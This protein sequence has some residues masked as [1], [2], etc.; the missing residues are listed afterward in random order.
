MAKSTDEYLIFKAEEVVASRGPEY[1]QIIPKISPRYFFSNPRFRSLG[2]VS[3]PNLIDYMDIYEEGDRWTLT[4]IEVAI[5]DATQYLFLPLTQGIPSDSGDHEYGKPAF[6]IE[7]SSSAYGI[8]QWQVF[9]AFAD[10]LFYQKLYNLFLPSENVPEN[11]VNAYINVR[12][13]GVGTF[14]FHTK[15]ELKEPIYSKGAKMEFAEP[16]LLLKFAEHNLRIYQLLSP[17]IDSKS[18]EESPE[19]AGW[20]EY[21]GEKGLRLLIGILY[22]ITKESSHGK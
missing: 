12:E 14:R 8:R 17:T 7:T 1:K 13:S 9:D 19:V 6:G 11:H 5:N 20:L 10:G 4:I 18:L 21:T 3:F 16:D 22:N 2:Q 15:H